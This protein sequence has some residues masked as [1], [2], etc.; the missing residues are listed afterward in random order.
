VNSRRLMFLSVAAA[1]LALLAGF[2]AVEKYS[3]LLGVVLAAV[4]WSFGMLRNKGWAVQ[5]GFV[6]DV[7]TAAYAVISGVSRWVALAAVLLLLAGWDLARFSAQIENIVPPQAAAR[8]QTIHLRRLGW[9]LAAGA[10]AGCAASLFHFQLGF[11]TAVVMG[12]AALVLL[13]L[14]IKELAR[15]G[16]EAS[17]ANHP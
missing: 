14:S 11:T 17:G 10:A 4:I 2:M 6:L 3:G 8:L 15:S 12:L 5:I 9:T 13:A 1:T 7:C 16:R